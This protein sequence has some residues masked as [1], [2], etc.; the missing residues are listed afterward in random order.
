MQISDSI[1]LLQ[2]FKHKVLQFQ[3]KSWKTAELV[4][5]L[6]KLEASN[7]QIDPCELHQKLSD[8][9][10]SVNKF[11]NEWDKFWREHKCASNN[12]GQLNRRD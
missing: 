9:I 1:K 8:S 7:I 12:K 5:K 10:E 4:E 2:S 11:S 6:K 3:N